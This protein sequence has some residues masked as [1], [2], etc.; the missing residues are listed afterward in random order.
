MTSNLPRGVAEVS[1]S[2]SCACSLEGLEVGRRY[3][4]AVSNLLGLFRFRVGDVLLCVGHFHKAPKAGSCVAGSPGLPV[5]LPSL[6]LCA[7]Q[8][9]AG[10]PCR[11]V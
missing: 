2:L 9:A 4:I 11:K 5:L 3:E 10:S 7:A 1:R 8:R 6:A